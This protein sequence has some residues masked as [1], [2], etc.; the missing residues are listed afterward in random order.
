MWHRAQECVLGFWLRWRS[1]RG[2][3]PALLSYFSLTVLLCLEMAKRTLP[4]CHSLK[5]M[6]SAGR[7]R[8]WG[9]LQTLGTCWRLPCLWPVHCSQNPA[10]CSVHNGSGHGP[11]AYWDIWIFSSSTSRC[12]APHL[13][14]QKI[15]NEQMDKQQKTHKRKIK[16]LQFI[17]KSLLCYHELCVKERKLRK[18]LH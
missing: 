17:I 7:W 8:Y 12:N 11:W 4:V 14:T 13:W 1:Y 18:S 10:R 6:S 9:Y 2:P 3:C 15:I 5:Q 16:Q